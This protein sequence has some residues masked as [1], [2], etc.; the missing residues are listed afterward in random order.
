MFIV[1]SALATAVRYPLGMKIGALGPRPAQRLEL[2]EYEACPFCRKVREALTMLDLEVLVKPSPRGGSRFR[3]QAIARGGKAQFPL[4]VDPNQ[5]VVLYESNAIVAHLYKH[6]GAGAPPLGLRLGPVTNASSAFASALRAGS[7]GRARPSH[8][9]AQPLDLWSFESSP[10]CRRAREVLCELELPYTLHNVAK[11]SP[12]RPAF[13]ER[14]GKMQV[15]YLEDPN[16]GTKMFE[17]RDIVRYL[18][19]TY[20]TA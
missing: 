9:P 13:I 1:P 20:G 16:T 15:P 11:G 4:L 18:R 5:D 7:G 17:S 6:Y 14:S 8:A 2:Y 12:G 19:A 3:D 10:Y